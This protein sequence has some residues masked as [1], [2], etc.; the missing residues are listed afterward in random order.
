MHVDVRCH[1]SLV[2]GAM[3]LALATPPFASW[4]CC[5]LMQITRMLHLYQSRRFAPHTSHLLRDA[6]CAWRVDH[7]QAPRS[8]PAFL[9]RTGSKILKACWPLLGVSWE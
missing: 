2:L 4:P 8:R 9:T 3:V 6:A 1:L 5:P 7:Q